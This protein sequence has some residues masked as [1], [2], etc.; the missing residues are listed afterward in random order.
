M[1][2]RIF[3]ALAQVGSQGGQAFAEQR[4]DLL[5][6]EVLLSGQH[7]DELVGPLLADSQVWEQPQGE[8]IEPEGG[9][10]SALKNPKQ[11]QTVFARGGTVGS[12]QGVAQYMALLIVPV[13]PR[14]CA[15][16]VL[17]WGAFKPSL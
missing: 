13:H 16:K 14:C 10:C 6:I 12:I 5:F 17:P 8:R 2:K 7:S 3:H 1:E 15:I 4:I 11:T 9:I